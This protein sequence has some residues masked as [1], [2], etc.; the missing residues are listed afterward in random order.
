MKTTMDKRP[1]TNTSKKRRP[2]QTRLI[3]YALIVTGVL[4]SL[5]IGFV[6]WIY[7]AL[8]S[9][10]GPMEMNSFLPFRSEKAKSRY[11][12]Y[13]EKMAEQW[14][15]HSEERLVTTSFGKTFMRISGPADAPPLVLIPGGGCNSLIW[16]ANIA[17]FSRNYRTYA[18]DNIY[19]Y[20]RSVY[21]RELKNGRDYSDWLNELFDTLGLGNSIRVIGYSYGGWVTGQYALHHPERLNH[22]V[23]IEP[24]YFALSLSGEYIKRMLLSLLPLRHFKSTIMYGAWADLAATGESGRRLVEDRIDYYQLCLEC[25]KFKQPVNP[26]VLSDPELRSLKPPMLFLTGNHETAFNSE[27]AIARI[28]RVNPA[29]KT[30]LIPNTGHDILFT[31]TEVVNDTILD[32]LKE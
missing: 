9:G 21:T 29:I 17:A 20:G 27:E 14:P 8:F 6:A 18:L 10:P 5:C 7:L 22:V 3:K 4:L 16:H 28:G 13:E 23:L 24:I 12:A 1:D 15:V 30:V 19:D 32:F 26:T 2:L 11:L 25:F 31:H